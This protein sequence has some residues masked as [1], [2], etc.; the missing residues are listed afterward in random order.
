MLQ[1]F[2]LAWVVVPVLIA[3]ASVA[4]ERRLGTLAGN[5]CLPVTARAQYAIKF[6]VALL[7][8]VVGSAVLG[9]MAEA[10]ASSDEVAPQVFAII[11][12]LLPFVSMVCFYASTLAGNL[13]QALVVAVVIVI[14]GALSLLIIPWVGPLLHLVI[15]PGL[16]VVTVGLGV[17]N[18]RT[19]TEGWNLW[20]SNLRVFLL[21]FLLLGI[22]CAGAHNRAWELIVPREP[23]HGPAVLTAARCWAPNISV[24][25]P[26]MAVQTSDDKLYCELLPDPGRFRNLDNPS[27]SGQ[28]VVGSN[29]VDTAMTVGTLVAVRADGTLW[30]GT[31]GVE[32]PN[33]NGL[34]QVVAPQMFQ[35]SSNWLAVANYS[36]DPGA[37]V[38]LKTNGTLWMW[39][40][41]GAGQWR[42]W[43]PQRV[44]TNSDWARILSNG[45]VTYA[46]RKSTN[47]W[48]A[49]WSSEPLRATRNPITTDDLFSRVPALDQFGDCKSVARFSSSQTAFVRPDG[50]LWTTLTHGEI[51]TNG[52]MK[53]TANAALQIGN[54]TNWTAVSGNTWTLVGLKADGSLW[55]WLTDPSQPSRQIA[56]QLPRRLSSQHDW[57]CVTVNYSDIVAL[58]ADGTLWDWTDADGRDYSWSMLVPS[59]KPTLLRN[60]LAEAQ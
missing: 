46:W 3:S 50:T 43:S 1:V 16:L 18:Y 42:Y 36:R 49:Y 44:G 25:P 39:A 2:A 27:V 35:G 5:L 14:I 28:L 26:V 41:N 57:L 31:A 60:I 32:F 45:G 59:R 12:V 8:G 21:T 30:S 7:L 23:P 56:T 51:A 11:L 10:A 37:V 52:I 15:W 34:R 24:S 29:W 20:K 40:P 13:I 38:L 33:G 9:G 53:L 48:T 54:E 47:G 22:V 17:R 55:L 6:F 58:A 19:V 4:E